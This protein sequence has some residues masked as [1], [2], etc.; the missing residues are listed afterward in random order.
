VADFREA[1]PD[2]A[3][4]H[5]TYFSYFGW[6]SCTRKSPGA[7]RAQFA[8]CAVNVIAIERD[9][10]GTGQN[11]ASLGRVNAKIG[12]RRLEDQPAITH[13]RA[14]N[15]QLVPDEGAQRFGL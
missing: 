10:G 6:Y 1:S 9:L 7:S 13:I 14:T 4:E 12:F 2:K 15:S 3:G 8:D 5:S 11:A